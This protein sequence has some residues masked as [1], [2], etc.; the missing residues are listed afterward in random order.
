M[1][2]AA[3]AWFLVSLTWKIRPVYSLLAQMCA[4][5]FAAGT[6]P[7]RTLLDGFL[8]ICIGFLL[9]L[10][11]LVGIALLPITSIYFLVVQRSDY[12]Q[13]RELI[14]AGRINWRTGTI[15]ET[16]A[17]KEADDGR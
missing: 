13:I 17:Q 14:K 1:I 12:R 5:R 7:F 11:P 8:F 4:T 15:K 6:S 9:M 2:L 16:P 10:L 3:V